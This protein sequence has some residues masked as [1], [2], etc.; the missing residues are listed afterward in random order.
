MSEADT[1]AVAKEPEAQATPAAEVQSAQENTS[2]LDD[3][4]SEFVTA[5]TPQPAPQVAATPQNAE[6]HWIQLR[7][8]LDQLKASKV[9]EKEASDLSQFIKDVRRDGNEEDWEIDGF[10]NHLAKT[11]KRVLEAWGRRDNPADRNKLLNYARS[12]LDASR[13]QK[14]KKAVDPVATADREAVAA[15]V[16]GT[17][18]KA[19][20]APA[21]NYGAMSDRDLD[22]EIAKYT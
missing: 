4:L 7:S 14:A 3:L 19:P 2:S 6:P 15:A 21:P 22:A 8:E 1:Q 11:D 20:E 18:T 10:L 17:S 16:R 13:A 12:K 5:T 9:A